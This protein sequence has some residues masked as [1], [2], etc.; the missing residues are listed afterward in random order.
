MQDLIF[1]AME[2]APEVHREQ[3]RKYTDEPYFGHLAE[4]AGLTNTAIRDSEAL[5]TAWLH[6]TVEDQDVDLRLIAA[7]FD[8]KVAAGVHA[9][10]DVES[11]NRS[12][13]EAASRAATVGRR[14]GPDYQ[15]GRYH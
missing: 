12:E 10:S 2:F 3:K 5:A 11:G 1:E 8:E 14:L 4:V 9:L 15:S 7:R 6:D 13:R